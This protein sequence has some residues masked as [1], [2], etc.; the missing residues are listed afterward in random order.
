MFCMESTASVQ[1]SRMK[2]AGLYP[3]FEK[4]FISQEI[5]FNKPSK[6]Y[7][8]KCFAQIPRFDSNKALMV[9]D[10]LTSDILGGIH[11]GMKTCWINPAG[12]TAPGNIQPDYEIKR[13]ADLP[14]LL[15][16]L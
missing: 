9:G 16:R 7:F 6:E 14:A 1:D 4:V 15:E 2:S 3:F 12:L 11:G 8:D 13:L 5:G 10:S